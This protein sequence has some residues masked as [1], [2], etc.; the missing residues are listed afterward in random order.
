MAAPRS[1]FD[2]V[3]SA[4]LVAAAC[5]RS[6][7][8]WLTHALR[9]AG[10]HDLV[11]GLAARAG[12]PRPVQGLLATTAGTPREALA[13]AADT[14]VRSIGLWRARIERNVSCSTA[15]IAVTGVEAIAQ[16]LAQ[17][18]RLLCILLRV[19]AAAVFGF[20]FDS[21]DGVTFDVA[22]ALLSD[23]EVAAVTDCIE[24][25]FAE[26]DRLA[27]HVEQLHA[28]LP[29]GS[30]GIRDG[31][32]VGSRADA[33]GT[34][35][36]LDDDV[37]SLDSLHSISSTG[38]VPRPASAPATPAAPV[39]PVPAPVAA[40]SADAV[41]A[42]APAST[43][44]STP[45]PNEGVA[46]SDVDLVAQRNLA[47]AQART[48]RRE[49]RA[50]QHRLIRELSA[51]AKRTAA[52]RVVD[53]IVALCEFLET[54]TVT[55][56]P[57]PAELRVGA[58]TVVPKTVVDLTRLLQQPWR[59]NLL[60]TLHLN[61]LELSGLPD[62]IGHL[63]RL[64]CLWLHNN[65]LTRLPGTM[66]NLC[67]LRLLTLGANRLEET[68]KCLMY[69]TS[70]VTLDLGGNR[71]R[72]VSPEILRPL[73]QLRRLCLQY[74]RLNAL[75]P[76][77][78]NALSDDCKVL[79]LQGNRDLGVLPD[80]VSHVKTLR[81]LN[82]SECGLKRLPEML[83]SLARL[84]ASA[85]LLAE[86][87]PDLPSASLLRL[88]LND[89]RFTSMVGI[90]RLEELRDL[91]LRGN[92]ITTLPPAI[93]RLRH[94]LLLDLSANRLTTLPPEIGLLS[95][96]IRLR[97][98]DNRLVSV[99][100]TVVNLRELRELTLHGNRSL[101]ALPGDV[102]AWSRLVSLRRLTLHDTAIGPAM[103][104]HLAQLTA[105]RSLRLS[106]LGAGQL[107]SSF[108][109]AFARLRYI[110]LSRNRLVA[111]PPEI[112][113][114]AALESLRLHDNQLVRLPPE[115]GNLQLLRQLS[116]GAN[117]LRELPPETARLTRLCY[118]DL[119]GNQL[120]ELP[121][122]FSQLSGSLSYLLLHD[123]QLDL[124]TCGHYM[125]AMQNLTILTLQGNLL[126]SV[127]DAIWRLPK[128][129]VLA[130][131]DN[132]ITSVPDAIGA[133]Q[134]LRTLTVSN[135]RLASL[136]DS[137]QQLTALMNLDV[138]GNAFEM[139]PRVLGSLPSLVAL[140]VDGEPNAG[141]I[142]GILQRAERA[143]TH[144][145]AVRVRH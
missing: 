21:V 85:N 76:G 57:F 55:T 12:R 26:I 138:R 7:R 129:T 109:D 78:L 1:P 110:D 80:D 103:P 11:A 14:A 48:V 84:E 70:L 58:T 67:K 29:A 118:L 143:E 88:S 53:F 62:A 66:A 16:H 113:R 126:P 116:L 139:L 3:P 130:L 81:I 30:G 101:G 24:A 136:P 60:H 104:L 100:E 9:R 31:A 87:P 142:I 6:L 74:G 127:P 112:G 33:R 2:G 119:H 54:E 23:D 36:A 47:Q 27:T 39:G 19:V 125:G 32:D 83:P 106:G 18:R 40:E 96:L 89:N 8:A 43:P 98:N 20:G 131:D 73:K 64:T 79:L 137:L 75:P 107:P 115:L 44:A 105:L 111:L 92:L 135:N 134:S 52:L 82:V 46:S 145:H 34:Y 90:A 72:Y 15:A 77:V 28:T 94:L 51:M 144:S 140:W 65:R 95:A 61:D 124:V 37:I 17:A 114:L 42:D 128:L 50:V 35:R 68:P 41:V 121:P 45:A 63:K 141:D 4:L 93:S 91:Q 120:R 22:S 56:A 49:L 99:P 25:K 69:M 5:E 122:G 123:N 132:A 10:P 59:Y 13:T 86:L 133:A 117:R 108:A 71:L 97:L 102:S 38:S